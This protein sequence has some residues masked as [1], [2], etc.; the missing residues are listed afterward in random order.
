MSDRS[1]T[2]VCEQFRA[3]SNIQ[4]DWVLRVF[5]GVSVFGFNGSAD[6]KNVW[7]ELDSIIENKGLTSSLLWWR[8]QGQ[9]KRS[10]GQRKFQMQVGLITVESNLIGKDWISPSVYLLNVGISV[11]LYS[12]L[13]FHSAE[14]TVSY[15]RGGRPI[16]SGWPSSIKAHLR[17]RWSDSIFATLLRRRRPSHL[18]SVPVGYAQAPNDGR[19]DGRN[20]G[21][22]NDLGSEP[23]LEDQARSEADH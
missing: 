12:H 4:D 20:N 16:Y 11:P 6:S 3:G 23:L 21:R 15:I 13:C 14:A 19:N 17:A 7:R 22:N 8:R 1:L 10:L 18:V 9:S 2:S 5:S